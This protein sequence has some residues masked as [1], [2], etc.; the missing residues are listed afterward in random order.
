V[1][2][3]PFDLQ[4]GIYNALIS[5]PNNLSEVANNILDP[6]GLRVIDK[7]KLTESQGV[8]NATFG[9]MVSRFDGQAGA[10]AYLLFILLYMPCVATIAV[11][12]RETN[13]KITVLVSLWTTT[14]AYFIAVAFYQLANIE[15]HPLQSLSWTLSLVLIF[16]T[17]LALL[18]YYGNKPV[19]H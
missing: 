18:R 6:L 17:M 3:P 16:V 1:A 12:Y 8:H 13:L 5:I 10:F 15:K 2:K 19:F 7:D 14:M 9:A 4:Q 11:I